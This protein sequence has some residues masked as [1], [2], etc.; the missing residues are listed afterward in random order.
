M[1]ISISVQ[2]K[3][4]SSSIANQAEASGYLHL[5]CNFS[6]HLLGFYSVGGWTKDDR[7]IICPSYLIV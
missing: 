7:I 5:G 3:G 6:L 4:I 2:F 1:K